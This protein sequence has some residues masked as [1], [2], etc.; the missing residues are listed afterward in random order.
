MHADVPDL[1]LLLHFPQDRDHRRDVGAGA[2][3]DQV[4]PG[5]FELRELRLHRRSH[6]G[7]IDLPDRTR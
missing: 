1:A 5:H 2:H 3:H 7:G 4:D 6:C